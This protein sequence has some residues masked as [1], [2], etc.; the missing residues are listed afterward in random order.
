MNF[1]P[2]P[3]IGSFINLV[4]P[5]MLYGNA[6]ILKALS[7]VISTAVHSIPQVLVYWILR[8]VLRIIASIA[9][10]TI[11]I[12]L[13]LVAVL[14]GIAVYIIPTLPG[15]SL[16]YMS[17]LLM[18]GLFFFAAILVLAFIIHLATVP[19]PIFMRYHALLF[20]R[21]WYTDIVPFWEPVP[22]PAWW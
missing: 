15:F 8:V 4:I 10:T 1:A 13:V 5:V 6:G 9:A 14:I 19:F 7:N 20:L 3:I 18:P 22:E 11:S 21:N 2:K 16:F 17:H 12:I